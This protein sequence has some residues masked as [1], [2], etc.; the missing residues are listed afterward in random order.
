MTSPCQEYRTIPLTQG[1]VAKVSPSRYEEL[2]RYR[3]C[4]RFSKKTRTFY[5]MRNEVIQGKMRVVLMHR[6]I[7]GLDFGDKRQ[8][9]HSDRD[10][11]N[12]TDENL[13]IATN[14]QN[15][16]NRI[17][18]RNNRGA[19][20]GVSAHG[21]GW[22]ARIA[23][24]GVKLRFSVRKTAEEAARDYDA[25]AIRLHGKFARLNFPEGR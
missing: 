10:T 11:L 25:A 23:G 17:R 14:A 20:K 15:Q 1:Q 24:S 2:S 3:W 19:F 9:E 7:L 22:R 12:N 4:A 18:N 16:Y 6:H 8:G 13:R 5:A 21:N